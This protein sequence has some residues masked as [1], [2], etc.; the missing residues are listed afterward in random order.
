MLPKYRLGTE[1]RVPRDVSPS[2]RAVIVGCEDIQGQTRLKKI[3]GRYAYYVREEPRWGPPYEL[4]MI[5]SETQI[6][7]WQRAL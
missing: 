1:I 4:W 7:E 6:E 3:P 2:G 5:V